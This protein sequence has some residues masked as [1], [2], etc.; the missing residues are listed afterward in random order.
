MSLRWATR[1]PW[2]SCLDLYRFLLVF[3]AYGIEVTDP[4]QPLLVNRPSKKDQRRGDTE[5]KYLLPEL[6]TLTGEFSFAC[7]WSVKVIERIV[8]P[9]GSR[10]PS[11]SS[12][13]YSTLLQRAFTNGLPCLISH[14][15]K[16]IKHQTTITVSYTWNLSIKYLLIACIL[17][18]LSCLY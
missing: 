8:L 7:T 13:Q 11:F 4:E 16:D 6:C 9:T 12:W 3:Q 5:N 17:Y 10:G 14:V 18:M 2:A 1:G 15:E